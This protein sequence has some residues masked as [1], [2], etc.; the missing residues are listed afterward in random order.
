MARHLLS[1]FLKAEITVCQMKPNE[2]HDEGF[3]SDDA[4]LCEA[5]HQALEHFVTDGQSR[6]PQDRPQIVAARLSAVAPI[7]LPK[8]HLVSVG[9]LEIWIQI[10]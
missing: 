8:R 2:G 1:L 10:V 4:V 3:D 7:V 6:L 9:E 5:Q